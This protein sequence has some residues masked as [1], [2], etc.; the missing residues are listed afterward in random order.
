MTFLLMLFN[1]FSFQD[2]RSACN[3]PYIKAKPNEDVVTQQDYIDVSGKMQVLHQI[4][5]RLRKDGHKTYG[6]NEEADRDRRQDASSDLS[7]GNK[8]QREQSHDG[9]S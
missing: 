7:S 8:D 4:F 5:E 3:H 9:K 1:L 2:L 6:E